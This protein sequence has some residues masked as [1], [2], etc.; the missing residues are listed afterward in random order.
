MA[1]DADV[2][3]IP[4]HSLYDLANHTSI[5]VG[6]NLGS[7]EDFDCIATPAKNPEKTPALALDQNDLSLPSGLLP[8]IPIRAGRNAPTDMPM[9]RGAPSLSSCEE[10]SAG[11]NAGEQSIILR[12]VSDPL[13]TIGPP[14]D[15]D[16]DRQHVR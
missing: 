13:N 10:I 9:H 1:S 15:S 16:L 6:C 4:T 3:E 5:S 8:R 11:M 14:R 2:V 7:I 12:T